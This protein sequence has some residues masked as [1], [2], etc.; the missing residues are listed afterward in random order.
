MK[1]KDERIMIFLNKKFISL[2]KSLK[3]KPKTMKS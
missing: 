1:L 3:N 2:N